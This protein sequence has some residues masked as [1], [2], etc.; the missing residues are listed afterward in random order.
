[1]ETNNY[2]TV[3]SG[4]VVTQW[5]YSATVYRVLLRAVGRLSVAV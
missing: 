1:V 5:P 2:F 3:A 4:K